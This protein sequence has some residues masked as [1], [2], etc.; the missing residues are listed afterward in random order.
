MQKLN[1]NETKLYKKNLNMHRNL[2]KVYTFAL[3]IALTITAIK[4]LS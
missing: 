1:I 3:V 4:G 2:I